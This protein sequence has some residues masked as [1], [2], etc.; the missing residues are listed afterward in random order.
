MVTYA[1][2]ASISIFFGGVA[3]TFLK[4]IF[5]DLVCLNKRDRELLPISF[6]LIDNVG[7]YNALFEHRLCHF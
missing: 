7:L 6:V 4:T 3:T 1:K 5:D 2:Y